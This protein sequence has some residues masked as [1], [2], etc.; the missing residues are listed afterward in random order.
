MRLNILGRLIVVKEANSVFHNSNECHGIYDDDSGT[1]TISKRSN[2]KKLTLLHEVIHATFARNGMHQVLNDE[3]E[4]IICD[5]L[6]RVLS[7]NFTIK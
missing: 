3:V 6:A 5:T 1:I 4:E 2:D 7:E